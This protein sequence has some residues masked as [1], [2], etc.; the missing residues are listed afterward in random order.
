M[1]DDRENPQIAGR[2]GVAETPLF[3]S[4]GEVC[5]RLSMS[6]SWLYAQIASGDVMIV[7]LGRRTLI[8]DVE[9]RRIANQAVQR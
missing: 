9:L 7:K 5:R 1:I 3:H 8:P 2:E 6:R 4:I